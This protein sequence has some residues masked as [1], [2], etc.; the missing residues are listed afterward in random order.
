MKLTYTEYEFYS[1]LEDEQ[2]VRLSVFHDGQEFCAMLAAE[3]RWR[4]RKA[5]A[6]ELLAEAIG[7]GAEPGDYTAQVREQMGESQPQGVCEHEGSG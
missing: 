2:Q 3:P 1:I 4:T 6:L 7:G 5:T